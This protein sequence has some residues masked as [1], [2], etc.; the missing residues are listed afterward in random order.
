MMQDAAAAQQPA[1]SPVNGD[2]AAARAGSRT[3][4]CVARG[5]VQLPFCCEAR[6]A[7]GRCARACLP[8][9]RPVFSISHFSA[10]ACLTARAARPYADGVGSVFGERLIGSFGQLPAAHPSTHV[11]SVGGGS[12]LVALP[13]AYPTLISAH[14]MRA[15]LRQGVIMVVMT[16]LPCFLLLAS[17]L[18]LNKAEALPEPQVAACIRRDSRE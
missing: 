7:C 3:R 8:V 14:P 17:Y 6:G 15:S 2:Y 16:L 4:C 10:R 9:C 13:R 11:V 1:G 5:V 12:H 18:A